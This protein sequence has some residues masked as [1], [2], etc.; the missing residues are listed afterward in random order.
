MSKTQMSTTSPPA[1][2]FAP[3]PCEKKLSLNTQ[4]PSAAVTPGSIS[5]NE[6]SPPPVSP[7]ITRLLSM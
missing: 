4:E 2:S 7:A 3:V 6:S 5:S 1:S